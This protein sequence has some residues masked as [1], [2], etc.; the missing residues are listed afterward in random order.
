MSGS[1]ARLYGTTV[2][3]THTQQ[4]HTKT[5]KETRPKNRQNETS[6]RNHSHQ[7]PGRQIGG[8][9]PH[10]HETSPSPAPAPAVTRHAGGA[11]GRDI[12]HLHT[13]IRHA[14]DHERQCA[15]SLA[16]MPP[17]TCGA[18][19]HET[20]CATSSVSAWRVEPA[21]PHAPAT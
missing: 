10:L 3:H 20:T 17:L 14:A 11:N 9:E 1:T 4:I 7:T 15:E 19:K 8:R 2:H 18:H 12:Q 21:Q 16:P 6:I 5:S 13:P